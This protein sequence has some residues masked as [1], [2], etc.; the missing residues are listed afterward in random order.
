MNK[1]IFEDLFYNTIIRDSYDTAKKLLK[2]H[3]ISFTNDNNG[4]VYF[5][6]DKKPFAAFLGNGSGLMFADEKIPN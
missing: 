6:L 2:E 4:N 3:N 1:R 5:I